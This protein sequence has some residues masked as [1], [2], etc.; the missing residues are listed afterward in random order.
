MDLTA[1]AG[2]LVRAVVAAALV[3]CGAGAEGAM[4]LSR[5]AVER[6][7]AG[8]GSI[9]L[10]GRDLAGLD[11]SGLSLDGGDFSY[12]NL[13]RAKLGRASLKGAFL[14]SARA[15]GADLTGSDLRRAKLGTADLSGADL[16]GADLRGADLLGTNLSLADLRGADLRETNPS[17]AI[18]TRVVHDAT[19]RWPD[20]FAAGRRAMG[21]DVVL[22]PADRGRRID[23][24]PGDTVTVRLP[25]NPTTGYQWQVAADS[26]AALSGIASLIH[27]GFAPAATSAAGASGERTLVF[28][29]RAPGQASLRLLSKPSWRGDEAAA[30]DFALDLVVKP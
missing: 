13:E 25:E 24:R 21:N 3:A 28:E 15:A 10:N 9:S 29:A 11:L 16:R 18:L 26:S 22:G 14:W 4:E 30:Q 7:L 1:K 20:G 8:G 5:E 23:I 2:R 6:M 27:Q 17:A 19:T 12:A